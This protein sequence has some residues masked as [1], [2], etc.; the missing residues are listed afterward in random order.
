[1]AK[2]LSCREAGVDCDFVARGD[3]EEE[4]LKS[5]AEHCLRD[6]GMQE[7]PQELIEKVRALIRDE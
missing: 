6:H 3:N 1:M 5:A 2:M 4:V 7:I